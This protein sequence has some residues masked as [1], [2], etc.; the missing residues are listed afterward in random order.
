[1]ACESCGHPVSDGDQYCSVCGAKLSVPDTPADNAPP[2]DE[3]VPSE[4]PDGGELLPPPQEPIP[5]EPA[6]ESQS[7]LPPP[8]PAGSAITTSENK[9]DDTDPTPEDLAA[10][11]LIV[12]TTDDTGSWRRTDPEWSL[13][14]EATMVP[15]SQV[16]TQVLPAT[17]PPTAVQASDDDSGAALR[18]VALLAFL[19]A[20]VAILST[21]TTLLSI[22]SD[23]TL[24]IGSDAPRAFRTGAWYVADLGDNLLIATLVTIVLLVAGAIGAMTRRRWGSG[25]AGG[26]GLALAGLSAL[27]LGLV[28]MP[29]DAAYKFAQIPT[30][31]SFTLTISRPVGYWVI[32]TAGVLGLVVF[33]VS[34][35]DAFGDR[36]GGLN[37]WIAAFGALAVVVATVGPL[38]PEKLAV[39]SDNWYVDPN[40][41]GAPALL[42]LARLIQLG[43]FTIAGVIGF[44]S[45]RRWGLGLM[46]GGCLPSVWLTGSA[47]A[48]LGDHPVGLAWL[49]PGADEM[50]VHAVTLVGVV[51]IV[52]FAIVA[53]IAARHR[54]S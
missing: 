7:T 12:Q 36:R 13:P 16:T 14:D 40:V 38:I 35:N 21:V 32:L 52:V 43:L 42:V 18:P 10:T 39:I 30:A 23:A 47:L 48:S 44:L 11:E 4:Q 24:P 49:N 25:L 46:I 45:V 41:N 20:V 34:L 50:S 37:P 2:S 1:M 53:L 51:F 8:E 5:N 19:A 17:P 15:A 28:Q 26:S 27:I 33:F 6:V 29:V 3:T 54:P 9:S 22:S 31:E